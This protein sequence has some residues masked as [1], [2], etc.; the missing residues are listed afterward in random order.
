MLTSKCVISP[1]F[2]PFRVNRTYIFND[3]LFAF[4]WHHKFN[5]SVS[6]RSVA[7]TDN[8]NRKPGERDVG[9]INV[10]IHWAILAIGAALTISALANQHIRQL[11]VTIQFFQIMAGRGAIS[12]SPR[13]GE[14]VSA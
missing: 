6:L 14:S 1:A 7:F 9:Q 5:R 11:Q 8:S 10:L 13:T 12:P 3:S 4:S 2:M